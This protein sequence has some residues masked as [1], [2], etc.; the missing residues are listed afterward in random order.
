[1]EVGVPGGRCAII[2]AH[3][4]ARRPVHEH[5][6]TGRGGLQELRKDFRRAKT[7][8]GASGTSSGAPELLPDPPER[9]RERPELFPE[10]PERLLERPERFSEHP[11]RLP[12]RPKRFSEHLERLPEPPEPFSER[13]ERLLERRN[14]FRSIRNGDGGR[15]A[16]FAGALPSPLMPLSLPR[17]EACPP[18]PCA[19]L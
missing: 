13:P 9:L 1:M 17:S 12:E 16:G 4:G 14:G 7:V 6:R 2:P 8:S 11:E 18:V 15:R 3:A 5:G 19:R 10:H